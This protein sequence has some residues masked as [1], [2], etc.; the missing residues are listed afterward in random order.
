M[1]PLQF[2]VMGRLRLSLGPIVVGFAGCI[3]HLEVPLASPSA[4]DA[5]RICR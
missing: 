3:L 1:T 5:C 4:F 2:S